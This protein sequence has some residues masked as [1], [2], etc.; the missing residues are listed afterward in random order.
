MNP[1]GK[2]DL[3]GLPGWRVVPEREG[4]G[5]GGKLRTKEGGGEYLG[6]LGGIST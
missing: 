5:I 1:P 3:K 2:S 6:L 4:I